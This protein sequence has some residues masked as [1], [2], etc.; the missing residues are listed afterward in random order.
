MNKSIFYNKIFAESNSSSQ[1]IFKEN[2]INQS[3]NVDINK[4]L[5]RIKL[6]KHEELKKN[7]LYF[8]KLNSISSFYISYN[9][10]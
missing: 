6:N 9:I 1:K 2:S 10:Y 5:N 7:Y 4:L 8:W 3:K